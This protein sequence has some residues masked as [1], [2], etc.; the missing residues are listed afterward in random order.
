MFDILVK[1]LNALHP[2]WKDYFSGCSTD[3][4]QSITGR[5]HGLATRLSQCI[6]ATL[7]QIW[8]GLHQLDLVMQDVFKSAYD[9]I[10]HLKLMALIGYLQRKQNLISTMCSTCPKVS[11]VQWVSMNSCST[12]LTIKI[13]LD[14]H[15]D[16]RLFAGGWGVPG[17]WYILLHQFCGDF[18][19]TF[20][21]T[22]TVESDFSVIGWEKN[23]YRTSLTDFSLEGILYCKQLKPLQG[24]QTSLC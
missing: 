6:S 2:P 14:T 23:E 10:F 21:N 13:E 24:L 19:S 5:I 18:A 11:D 7:V 16:N 20:P 15:D 8:C 1:F 12:W 3:G 4:A 9:D 17:S 22:A